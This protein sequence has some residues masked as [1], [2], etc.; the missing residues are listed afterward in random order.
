MRLI[1]PDNYQPEE[2]YFSK[3]AAAL[4]HP[5]RMR[6]I[7]LLLSGRI[8]TRVE[9]CSHFRVSKI[10]LYKHVQILKEADL[11]TCFYNI[12]FEEIQLNFS[13]LS[14]ARDCID[15]MLQEY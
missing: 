12:H 7:E 15:K 5:L 9:L 14:E 1:K 3:V 6:I 11:I 4:S 8:K 10:A 13:A 2:L